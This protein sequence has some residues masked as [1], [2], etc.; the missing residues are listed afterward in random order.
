[1][2]AMV[3][4]F[5]A[6]ITSNP[7]QL[8]ELPPRLPGPGELVV[9]VNFCGV[10]HTDLHIVEGE[11]PLARLPLIPGHQVVGEVVD[12]GPRT[13]RFKVGD[14]VG[15]AWLSWACGQ[16][17]YCLAGLE[18]LCEKAQFTGFHRDGGYAQVTVAPE[19]FAYR[20][21]DNFPDLSAAPLLCAGII[22]YRALKLSRIQPGGRLGLYG[23][24]GSA[25]IAIQIARH[26][27]C[28]VYVFTR[29]PGHQE[30][31]R[32]LGAAWVGRAQNTAPELLDSAV[33][34]APA[35]NL[36]PEALRA[37]AKGGTLAL[38]GIYM[39][40]IP[41][42]DYEKHLY[43]EKTVCSVTASTRQDGEELLHLAA[44]IPIRTQT[45]QFPLAEAN[46]A[47]QLLKAGKIN[48]AAV[49]ALEP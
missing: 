4:E 46:Q 5:P 36:V 1:M 47:L 2:Q 13:R 33:I 37:L 40:Q 17:R 8:T 35:G 45:Q 41:A 23:F 19:D 29:S 42:L 10:C 12:L 22:G 16:C 20:L 3:L 34:F 38:A 15:L 24:G 7:L 26:W 21:P 48:G 11:L 32:T 44:A 6:P 25:H 18:N 30:L 43:Y 9:K 28:Q 14:R 49:L 39:S 31:A 27:N